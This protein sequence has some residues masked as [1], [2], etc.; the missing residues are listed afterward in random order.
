MIRLICSVLLL[1]CVAGA[2]TKVKPNVIL[3][4]VDDMGWMDCGAYGSTYYE[5]PNIDAFAKQAMRFTQAY[6]QPLCS[7]TRASLLTG[8]YSSR[9]RITSASGH[10]PPQA[11]DASLYPDAAGP[12]AP[13]LFPESK[14][15]LE[16]AQY[17]LA[18][19]LHDAG[20]RTGHFGKWHL[21]LT[22]PY[23]PERQGFDLAFHAEPSA[24]PPGQYFSPY[25]V[26]PP[27][28]PK[29]KGQR[30]TL[31]TFTDGPSGEY[32]TDRLTDEALKFIASDPS[33][34]F[35][36]NLWHF[37]V[38][39]P[40]GH[41]EAYT[42]EFAKKTD[43]RGLQ[44]NP[45]MASMLKS[46]DES[47]GRILT[48]LDEL[49]IS[50]HTI[51]IFNSDNGGNTHSM[52]EE[53]SKD[54]RGDANNP[55]TPSYRK[56]AGYRPPTNNAPLRDGKG[57]LYEGGVRVPLMVRWP[58]RIAPSSTSDTV[59]GCIDLYPTIR[60]LLEIAPSPTQ[61]IDGLSYAPVLLGTG[62][63]SREDYFI[64]FPHLIPG[65]SVRHGDWK[66]IRRFEERP[67]DYEGL[68]ELFNLR[69]DPGETTNLAAKLPDKVQELDTRISGFIASTGALPPK[70]NPAYHPRGPAD[71]I[72]GLVPKFCKATM[73]NG[74]LRIEADG[75]TPFL[76]TAQVKS[77]GP[78][79]M[80]L[81]I[82]SEAG[83]P[84]RIQWKT[85][86]QTEFP[87]QG[88]TVDFSVASGPDWQDLTV[89]IPMEGQAGI[90][91]I[92]LP[93]ISKPVELE[94]IEFVAADGKQKEWNFRR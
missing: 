6:A 74:A 80:K 62:T 9:H 68:Y 48:K 22:Q 90:I 51:V 1:T 2:A 85:A 47:L 75:R 11:P 72:L 67:D 88:Q 34:P 53:D 55:N 94:R 25:G 71:P 37:G 10:L 79:T 89:A 54:G 8:Q 19:A 7:P 35:F 5:T 56:W 16:P 32:I 14:N 78:L 59:V 81:R 66:L 91:R 29:S 58:G 83:G 17:T 64:W 23:W 46:I 69:D 41:K 65:V 52:T 76:G 26:V 36:L 24:G 42:A 45:V 86:E 61:K 31:G 43:P 70:P 27:G 12:N 93:A 82:R 57:R 20:Y 73:V 3:F 84:G 33:K 38:H 50:D 87:A 28:T 63:I 18:E 60:D 15:Y 92:Y 13:L 49:G 44:N 77:T 21:G 39:G 4:L 30:Q 40:W